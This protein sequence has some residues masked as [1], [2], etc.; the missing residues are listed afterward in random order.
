MDW[1]TARGLKQN[2]V[3]K[4][5]G[6]TPSAISK[7]IERELDPNG[8]TA[9]PNRFRKGLLR[10]YPGPDTERLCARWERGQ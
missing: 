8:S 3:A 9:P 7:M 6:Y 4:T 10:E 5:L 2:A 1:I